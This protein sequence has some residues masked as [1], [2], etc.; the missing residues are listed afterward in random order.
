MSGLIARIALRY[1]AGALVFHGLFSADD[2]LW[3]NTDP[4]ILDAVSAGLGVAIGAGTEFAYKLAR[5]WGWE[6]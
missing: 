2:A 5:K 4:G 1:V 3:L 6:T